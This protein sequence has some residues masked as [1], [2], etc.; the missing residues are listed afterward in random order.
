MSEKESQP[1]Q[2]W[3]VNEPSWEYNDEY[4]YPG[5]GY[6]PIGVFSDRE[7]AERFA[8]FI[9]IRFW[10]RG[11]ADFIED[12]DY[13]K[14]RFNKYCETHSIPCDEDSNNTWSDFL[15]GEAMNMTDSQIAECLSSFGLSFAHVGSPIVQVCLNETE[16][17]GGFCATIGGDMESLV[18][19]SMSGRPKSDIVTIGKIAVGTCKCDGCGYA[20]PAGVATCRLCNREIEIE[21]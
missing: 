21:G 5:E 8:K 1:I 20:N 3:L 12:D 17:N 14:G 6:N 4:Y 16:A 19:D 9:S 18:R 2:L 7:V 13:A 11:I 10:K 15:E